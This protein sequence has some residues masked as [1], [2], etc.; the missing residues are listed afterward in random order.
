VH[1]LARAWYPQSKGVLMQD[2]NLAD[3]NCAEQHEAF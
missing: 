1:R 2:I 3:A